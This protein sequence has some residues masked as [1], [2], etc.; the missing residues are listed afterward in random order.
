MNFLKKK[1]L[2]GLMMDFFIILLLI[3]PLVTKKS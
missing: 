1:Y 2:I 3:R